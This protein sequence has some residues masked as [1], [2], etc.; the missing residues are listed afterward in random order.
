NKEYVKAAAR[1]R[2]QSAG[3]IG[4]QYQV[5]A[6][7]S[8]PPWKKFMALPENKAA[9]NQFLSQYITER[10]CESQALQSRHERNLVIA[11]GFADGK[12]VVCLSSEGRTESESL[13]STH[14]EADTRMIL[15]AMDAD[16][17]FT[18]DDGRIVIKTPDTDV[19]VLA[20]YYFPRMKHVS[21]FWIETGR[22]TKTSDQRRFIPIHSISKSLGPL[23]C[24]VLPAIHALTG[25]DST[26]AL[27]GIGKKSVLKMIQ[28]I[29][30][31]EFADLSELYG[32]DEQGA[33]RAGRKLIASLY[34]PKHK[35]GKYH[36]SLN[37]LRFRLA[38]TKETTLSKLPP[39]EASFE[40]HLRRA[41]WQAK[42]WTH[43]HQS[44]PNIPSPVGHGW[45]VE[46]DT[47][48]PVLFDGP[49]SAEVLRELVCSCRGRNICANNCVCGTNSL[50][51]TEICPCQGDDKC[52]NEQNK[53]LVEDVE[54]SEE[55]FIEDII[56]S[57]EL[58]QGVTCECAGNT[59]CSEDC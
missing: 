21:E 52:Q 39:S 6:G 33:L 36:S 26:S 18:D 47:I 3:P 23:F 31:G 50:P 51:C 27:F 38:T 2:R 29:G 32:N 59:I 35:A 25:C 24:L 49:V 28:D 42:M 9:L 4:R 53:I 34:D 44:V 16:S 54:E 46:H 56:S 13:A 10:A 14:E 12:T 19:V 43:A 41:S 45:K 1:D 20:L 48:I 37:D 8:I 15:H 57:R 11:G 5:I 17:K 30:I 40:Q 55:V 58:F 22:V 7:R